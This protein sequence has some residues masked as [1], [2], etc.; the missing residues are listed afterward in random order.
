MK[1]QWKW[2]AKYNQVSHD[3]GCFVRIK[4]IKFLMQKLKSYIKKTKKQNKNDVILKA[5]YHWR[6]WFSYHLYKMNKNLNWSYKHY[7]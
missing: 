7:I 1:Y 5:H 2:G 4:Q 3:V 6:S